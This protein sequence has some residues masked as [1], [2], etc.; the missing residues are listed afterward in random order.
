MS[1]DPACRSI[2]V[3]R[4]YRMYGTGLEALPEDRDWSEGPLV[5][6]ERVWRP[7]QMSGTAR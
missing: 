5:G 1:E 7:L 2:G 3:G 4:P 6:P